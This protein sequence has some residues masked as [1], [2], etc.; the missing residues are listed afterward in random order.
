MWL[1]NL[2]VSPASACIFSCI[3]LLIDPLWNDCVEI[4]VF[5]KIQTKW[6]KLTEWKQ[7]VYEAPQAHS[8]GSAFNVSQYPA[9]I[10]IVYQ[11][12]KWFNLRSQRAVCLEET[13]RCGI[14]GTMWE[15]PG[16]AQPMNLMLT[17]YD[18]PCQSR[19]L[20]G[21]EA[22]GRTQYLR[23]HQLSVFI[24]ICANKALCL[25]MCA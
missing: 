13:T 22:C 5:W 3:D 23:P 4:I 7:Q 24:Y 14:V 6:V 16:R 18:S 8:T 19:Y 11:S 17:S 2:T 1:N 12:F 9:F 10:C 21:T 20:R 25:L 15:C